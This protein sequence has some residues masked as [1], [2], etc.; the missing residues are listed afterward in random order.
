MS[1]S[2]QRD[3]R[4][5]AFQGKPSAR[6]VAPG[7]PAARHAVPAVV[8]PGA[9]DD[10]G[11]FIAW[12]LARA[13]LDAGAY[14]AEPLLRRLQACLRALKVR[15]PLAARELIERQPHL[16]P[17]AVSALLI[18]GRADRPPDGAKLRPAARYVYRRCE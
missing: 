14:R 16:A 17:T 5:I 7:A 10:P 3:L 12:V 6:P 8:P 2:D 4:H 13:G 11:R 9:E 18:G 1:S 15:S